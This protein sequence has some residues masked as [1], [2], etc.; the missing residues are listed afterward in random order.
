MKSK[1]IPDIF[2]E[3]YAL[4]LNYTYA[5]FLLFISILSAAAL[6]TFDINDNSFLTNTSATSGN[7]LGDFG[8][9]YASLVFYTFGI[10]GYLI[11]LF[12]L[13]YS[14]LV[15]YHKRPKYIFIRLITFFLSLVLIPQTL[16]H[17]NFNVTFIDSLA[18][19]G[20]FAENFNS[21]HSLNYINYLTSIIGLV[22]YLISQN[23][24]S[25][26]KIPKIKF[27]NLFN[28]SNEELI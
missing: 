24:I 12:F 13:I 25:L 22:F 11:I 28:N 6:L 16:I 4:F 15:F 21:L 7:F 10:L 17:I 2:K 3:K 20:A 1:Y 9:Y 27:K 23:I 18:T 19:W 14:L 26:I 5:L 8:S